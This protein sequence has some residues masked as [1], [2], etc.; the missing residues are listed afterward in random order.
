[1]RFFTLATLALS[2]AAITVSSQVEIAEQQ[3]P[4]EIDDAVL[5]E[6]TESDFNW[7]DAHLM[8]KITK[9]L[10]TNSDNKI[11]FGEIDKAFAKYGA[12][13]RT[14]GKLK[15]LISKKYPAAYAKK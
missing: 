14:L 2:A 11:T 15:H 6:I 4:V 3:M 9:M 12:S 10:D 7:C 8:E 1:M 5:A 13:K